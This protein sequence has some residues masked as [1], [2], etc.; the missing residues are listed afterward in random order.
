MVTVTISGTPGSGKTTV[1]RLLSKRLGVGY[2]ST[3]L[4]FRE[5]AKKYRM[6]LEEFSRYCET[7]KEIDQELDEFQLKTLQQGDV[8][9]EGR[10]A[11]WIAVRNHITAVKVLIDADVD[12]RASR[13]VQREQ[14]LVPQRRNEILKR[15]ESEARRYKQYYGIDL[16]D[17]SIYDLVVDSSKETPE[18]ITQRIVNKIG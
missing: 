16:S 8:I 2:I 1:G 7:H 17:T 13:I 6:S 11:G 15:E 9:V 3:G 18:K 4:I 14:G 5:T 12:M 10:I